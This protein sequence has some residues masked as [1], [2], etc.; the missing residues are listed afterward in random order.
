MAVDG[1][2]AAAPGGSAC[3]DF[4][5]VAFAA[6]LRARLPEAQQ[7]VEIE[8]ATGGMSNPTYFVTCGERR[9]VMRKKPA[10]QLSPA[11]HRID[12]EYRLLSALAGSDVPVPAPV[13]YCDDADVIGTPFY[14]MARL[15]G[16]VSHDYTLPG[17]AA[18]ARPTGFAGMARALAA[19][20]RFDWAGAGLSDFG[21]PGN[22]FARQVDGWSRQWQG[23]G[24]DDTPEI[25]RL[26]V[27]LRAH[28]P[29]DD[30]VATIAHG[31]FRAANVMFRPDGAVSGVFDWELATI[32]HPLADLGFCLQGWLLAP[33]ENGGLAGLDLAALGIPAMRDFVSG[34]YAAAPDMPG[35]RAFH[36][37]FAMYR[38]AVGVSGVAVRARS[39]AVPDA[40]AAAQASRF[41][42]AYAKAGFN[43]IDSGDF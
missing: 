40:N 13:L 32:G 18:S 12:R 24:I 26:E 31:D 3:A 8:P 20:H 9:L 33:D 36:I 39:G 4:D 37:A 30:G 16:V 42:K 2:D 11:A 35:L 38:A 34:Y 21:K 5:T 7:G 23:F 22:Y 28:M 27:W 10:V 14:L 41:A 25:D 29:A 6:W 15:E 1:V 17:L 19:I 43:A